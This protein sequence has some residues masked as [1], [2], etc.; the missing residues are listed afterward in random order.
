MLL[1]AFGATQ[2]SGESVSELWA[3]ADTSP[4]KPPV[5]AMIHHCLNWLGHK[6]PSQEKTR[7]I[8]IASDHGRRLR[9]LFLWR[10]GLSESVF[11]D[12]GEKAIL[13]GLLLTACFFPSLPSPTKPGVVYAHVNVCIKL[14]S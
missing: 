14:N 10:V 4:R 3:A 5:I 2:H 12:V 9:G 1:A 6:A 7:P 8:A 11:A 13:L